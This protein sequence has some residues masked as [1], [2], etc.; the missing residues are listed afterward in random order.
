LSNESRMR[1]QLAAGW[2]TLSHVSQWIQRTEK[3]GL[4]TESPRLDFCDNTTL[5]VVGL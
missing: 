1:W 2:T 3:T 5:C 4:D